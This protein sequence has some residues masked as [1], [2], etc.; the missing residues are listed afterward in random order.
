MF[1]VCSIIYQELSVWVA[2]GWIAAAIVVSAFSAPIVPPI[3][4]PARL[5]NYMEAAGIR[6]APIEAP[7]V[8][9]PLTQGLSDEFGWR[10]QEQKVAA[11]FHQLSHDQ[12]RAAIL[13]STYGQTAAIDVYGSADGLPPALS[14]HNQYWL[15]GP[16]GYDGSLVIHIGGDPERWRRVCGSLEIVDKTDNSFAMP[17]ENS[18][19][20]FVCRDMR[21]SVEQMWGR[22]KRYR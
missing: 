10:E 13:A 1:V 5:Q 18:R 8:G 4:A 22:L 17:Y 21:V 16:R 6:P 19:P 12:K 7:G 11:V 3:L 9:A 15:W 20:I 14:G 2:R